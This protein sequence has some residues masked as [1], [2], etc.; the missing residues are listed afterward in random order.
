M[1]HLVLEVLYANK[2]TC[3]EC[4]AN[5]KVEML[6]VTNSRI[7]ECETCSELIQANEDE[8]CI[9]CQ[10]GEVKCPTEQVMWN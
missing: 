2:L 5:Q 6:G 8:C 9:C 7:F 1:N 3:P 4:H 10:Y